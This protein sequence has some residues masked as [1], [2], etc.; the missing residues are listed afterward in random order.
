MKQSELTKRQKKCYR[1]EYLENTE[2]CESL[3]IKLREES[4]GFQKIT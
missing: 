3:L 1:T 4:V 2:D